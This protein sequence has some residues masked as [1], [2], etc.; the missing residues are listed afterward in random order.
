MKNYSAFDYVQVH[1]SRSLC[2][3]RQTAQEAFYALDVGYGEI[4]LRKNNSLNNP[5]RRKI[6]DVNGNVGFKFNNLLYR[7]EQKTVIIK[8]R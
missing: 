7:T 8:G 3:N 1:T 6:I 2:T 5:I 4:V